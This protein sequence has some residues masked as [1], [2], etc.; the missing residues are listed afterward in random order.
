MWSRSRLALVN[1][2]WLQG[3]R[4]VEIGKRGATAKMVVKRRFEALCHRKNVHDF[5]VHSCTGAGAYL[6]KKGLKFNQSY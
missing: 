5:G 6:G 1:R 3:D 2:A 4:C